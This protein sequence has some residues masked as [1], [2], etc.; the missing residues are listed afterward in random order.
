MPTTICRPSPA[1]A[2]QAAGGVTVRRAR[3]ADLD[4]LVNLEERSFSGDR[5]SRIQYR[6]HLHSATAQV[7]VASG[8]DHSMLGSAVLF[9]RADSTR[10][11]LYSLATR[12]EARGRGVGTALLQAAAETA[13]AHGCRALR[14]E[15]RADNTAAISLY[16]R[17]G[18][19][20]IGGYQHYYQDDAD[21]WRYEL[22]LD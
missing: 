12:P 15:V 3:P 2:P 10:A 11:R 19:R 20:R 5:L 1:H 13:R 9:F 18:Y 22:A 7:L 4:D 16:E 8:S 6:R 17:M 14:L 21:A